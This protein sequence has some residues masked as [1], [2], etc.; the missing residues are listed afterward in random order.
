MANLKEQHD[1]EH[2]VFEVMNKRI[3]IE[4]QKMISEQT[5]VH[6]NIHIQTYQEKVQ[7]LS[8]ALS[9]CM[10]KD[11]E[12]YQND[13]NKCKKFEFELE[14]AIQHMKL[15]PTWQMGAQVAEH[16]REQ[17]QDLRNEVVS[18][19]QTYKIGGIP[20]EFGKL[21]LLKQGPDDTEVPTMCKKFM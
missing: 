8:N 17:F 19:P 2:M 5:R 21:T 20:L 11:E 13:I 15:N 18:R 14:Q 1:L 12:V 16:R 3:Q 4:K 7:E 10:R 6:Y 9:N